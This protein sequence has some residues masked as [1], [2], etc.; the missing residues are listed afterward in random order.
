[1]FAILYQTSLLFLNICYTPFKFWESCV[2][3]RT[4]SRIASANTYNLC[5]LKHMHTLSNYLYTIRIGTF[6]L[7]FIYSGQSANSILWNVII[8]IS[9]RKTGNTHVQYYTGWFFFQWTRFFPFDLCGGHLCSCV[10]R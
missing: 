5:V 7:N 10:T 4:E 3:L 8:L 6:F 9:Y 2:R 1:M